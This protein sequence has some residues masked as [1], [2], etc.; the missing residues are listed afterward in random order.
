MVGGMGEEEEGERGRGEGHEWAVC[1]RML[2]YYYYYYPPLTCPP[3]QW[4]GAE[5]G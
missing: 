3:G 4:G 5:P 1:R 2:Y